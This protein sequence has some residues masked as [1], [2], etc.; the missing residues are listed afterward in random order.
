MPTSEATSWS[1][2]GR[3]RL[4]PTDAGK[5]EGRQPPAGGQ[6]NVPRP[7]APREGAGSPGDRDLAAL[8]KPRSKIGQKA[9]AVRFEGKWFARTGRRLCP[10]HLPRRDLRPG[11][12]AQGGGGPDPGQAP[13]RPNRHRGGY[14]PGAVF[15]VCSDGGSEFVGAAC[16]LGE[17]E[18][19]AELGPGA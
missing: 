16:A 12:A 11:V 18:G 3:G 5:Q 15:A 9:Y 1:W 17:R 13:Q 14:V 2:P 8:S 19:P 7:Q 6:R 4:P 10:V